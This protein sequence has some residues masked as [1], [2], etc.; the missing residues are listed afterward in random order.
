MHAEEATCSRPGTPT[1]RC[2]ELTD[3]SARVARRTSSRG[4][5]AARPHIHKKTSAGEPDTVDVA[6]ARARR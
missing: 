5:I 1:S 3:R 2:A 4:V 6:V